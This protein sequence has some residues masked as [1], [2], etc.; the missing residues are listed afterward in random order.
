[1]A[2]FFV[3]D[4]LHSTYIDLDL[5][6]NMSLATYYL[7]KAF[8][9]LPALLY[10]EAELSPETLNNYRIVIMPSYEIQKIETKSVSVSFNSYSLAEMSPSAIQEYIDNLARITQGYFM[11]VNHTRN[12]VVTADNFGIEKH[13]FRLIERRI[14][15]WTLSTNPNADEYEFLYQA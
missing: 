10:G 8:P 2:Y 13:G 15:G 7:L 3:R 5:P 6:E 4:N 14:A 12:A 1:M 9:T 11:H